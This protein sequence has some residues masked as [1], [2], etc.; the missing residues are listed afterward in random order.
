[1]NAVRDGHFAWSCLLGL[2]VNPKP[3][4]SAFPP[5]IFNKKYKNPEA[6]AEEP[7][8]DG[9]ETTREAPLTP[10]PMSE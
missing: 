6:P 2:W 7:K 1:M 3:K 8:R 4:V 10:L 9:S 5:G